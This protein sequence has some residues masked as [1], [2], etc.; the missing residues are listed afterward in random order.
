[1]SPRTY[2]S[3][4]NFHF[5]KRRNMARQLRTVAA[6]H[7][8]NEYGDLLLEFALVLECCEPAGTEFTPEAVEIGPFKHPYSKI[9]ATEFDNL[10]QSICPCCYHEVR[11]GSTICGNCHY[12][13][14]EIG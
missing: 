11:P 14:M 6:Q 13:E 10:G 8:G 9:G 4:G 2:R 5:Y 7:A 1:M 3:L 12:G